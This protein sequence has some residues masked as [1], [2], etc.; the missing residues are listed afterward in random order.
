MLRA[1]ERCFALSADGKRE[2]RRLIA[3]VETLRARARARGRLTRAEACELESLL[4]EIQ[5]WTRMGEA[6]QMVLF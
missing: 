3:R 6:R 2:L 4:Q 5:T 1:K